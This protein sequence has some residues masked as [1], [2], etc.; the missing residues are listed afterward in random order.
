MTEEGSRKV[1]TAEYLD[2]VVRVRV[3]GPKFIAS[4]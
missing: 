1:R 2:W 3:Y 4:G